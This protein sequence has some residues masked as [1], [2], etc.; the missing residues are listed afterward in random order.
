[1][2]GIKSLRQP[3]VAAISSAGQDLQPLCNDAFKILRTCKVVQ[4]GPTIQTN[5]DGKVV[6]VKA[7]LLTT[8]SVLRLTIW[9]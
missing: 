3:P 7:K 1:M 6:L 2:W 4:I 9:N 8:L 5:R